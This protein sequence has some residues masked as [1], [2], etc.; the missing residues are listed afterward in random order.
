MEARMKIINHTRHGISSIFSI[1]TLDKLTS[2]F[3]VFDK[4]RENLHF[5]TGGKE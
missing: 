1:F 3:T 4:I 5:K 2:K